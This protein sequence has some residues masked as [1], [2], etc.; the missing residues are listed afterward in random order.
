MHL[1][2]NEAL[3]SEQ[4]I[5]LNDKGCS[6]AVRRLPIHNDRK[7]GL[8]QMYYPSSNLFFLGIKHEIGLLI[9]K[10]IVP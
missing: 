10:M 1:R 4:A 2:T 5:G 3:K 6:L 7:K 9:Q 8:S